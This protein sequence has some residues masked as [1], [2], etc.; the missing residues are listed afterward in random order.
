MSHSNEQP[1]SPEGLSRP[2][3]ACPKCG[4][5]DLQV[6]NKKHENEAQFQ[7]DSNFNTTGTNPL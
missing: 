2:K 1:E 5:E 6:L 3:V 7:S 4:K